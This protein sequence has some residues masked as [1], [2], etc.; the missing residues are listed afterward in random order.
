VRIIELFS[1]LLEAIH[2]KLMMFGHSSE[3]FEFEREL[4]RFAAENALKVRLRGGHVALSDLDT[5]IPST[6]LI[7]LYR[8]FI[9]IQNN[10]FARRLDAEIVHGLVPGLYMQVG[11]E[12]QDMMGLSEF[13]QIE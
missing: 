6:A 8:L 11:G 1:F 2:L 3:A 9:A 7:D 10:H 12:L 4:N 13:V 5:P